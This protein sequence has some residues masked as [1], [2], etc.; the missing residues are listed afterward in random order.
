M[1]NRRQFIQK[2]AKSAGATALASSWTY[3]KEGGPD[4]FTLAVLPDTQNYSYRHPHVY[5]SQTRWLK[6]AHNQFKLPYRMA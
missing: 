6:E 1:I 5:T 3:A 4:Y 2:G